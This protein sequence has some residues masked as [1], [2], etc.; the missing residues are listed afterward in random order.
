M[1]LPC[2]VLALAPTTQII[3]LMR[4]SVAD[5]MAQNYIRVARIR[6]LSTYKI[7]TQHVLRNAIPPIIP[8]FGVQLSTMLTFAI[9]T[10]SIFNWPGIGRWLLDALSNRDY[11]SIQAGVIVVATLVLSASVLSDLV[12]AMI[13][14]LVRKGWYANK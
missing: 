11:V 1:I 12:G 3:R 5:V 9:V 14:P 10:E 4:S 8:K 2:I 7:I 6:G 13:N